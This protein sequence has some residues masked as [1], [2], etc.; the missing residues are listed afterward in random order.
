MTALA[1]G[2]G[3][4]VR[5]TSF[6]SWPVYDADDE[7]ALLDVLHSGRWFLADRVE[8]FER[9]FAAYQ[10]AQYGVSISSGT[11]ALQVDFCVGKPCDTPSIPAASRL[12]LGQQVG[13][14]L[15]PDFVG[16]LLGPAQQ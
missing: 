11:T 5:T 13:T 8:E 15:G 14:A 6:P 9:V 1:V 10:D 2:G 3:T 4:P 16:K 7:K 12:E